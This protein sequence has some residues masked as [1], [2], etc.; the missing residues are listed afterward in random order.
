MNDTSDR[1]ERQHHDE[2][3]E[4]DQ[5]SAET[6]MALAGDESPLVEADDGSVVPDEDTT[7]EDLARLQRE[8][9]ELRDM[10]LRRRAEFE[11]FR[12]RTDREKAQWSADAEA[13]VMQALIP[14]L[15]HLEQALQADGEGRALREGVELIHR[16][17]SSALER[18]GL[19][20]HDPR[21]EAF[22]PNTD[23]ALAYEPVKGHEEGKVVEVF[24]K[25]YLYKDRLIRPALV[26]VA[27]G[28]DDETDEVEASK[29]AD[30]A[31]H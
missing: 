15:D 27:G 7:S 11:N 20:V 31:V 19:T 3:I 4:D 24:R 22:D 30:D 16:D 25:G 26:K 12:R 9:D 5:D 1:D 14:T 13:E 18:M 29:E 2:D 6:G 21:G 28:Q 23:Q 17:L 8:C 10:L